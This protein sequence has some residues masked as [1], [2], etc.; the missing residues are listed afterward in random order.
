MAELYHLN[1]PTALLGKWRGEE[2]DARSEY[3][4]YLEGGSLGVSGIDDLD[5]EN[6]R[7]SNITYNSESIEFDTLM[8]STERQ[9]HLV[10][11]RMRAPDRAEMRFSF[12]DTTVSIAR[13]L[14]E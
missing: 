6:Y 5:G 12:T 10:L 9:G 4:I 13:K 3:R 1:P 11:T 2:D 8:P 14:A 7:I